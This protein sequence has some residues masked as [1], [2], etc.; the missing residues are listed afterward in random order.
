MAIKTK[1][2]YACGYC[3]KEF[4]GKDGMAQA[5]NCKDSHNLIYLQLSKEDL[6]KLIMFI[7][8]KDDR[9]LS[10]TIVERLQSYLKNSFDL[11]LVEKSLKEKK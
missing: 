1:L 5:E 8:S 2:G 11:S 9:V 7:Y 6:Q 3:K 4:T 10:D